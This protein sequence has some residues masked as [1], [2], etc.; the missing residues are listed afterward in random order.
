[1][2]SLR[3]QNQFLFGYK[4]AGS[5]DHISPSLKLDVVMWLYV[6]AN[7]MSVEVI[8]AYHLGLF[9]VCFKVRL[10][11]NVIF[12]CWPCLIWEFSEREKGI[13]WLQES[14]NQEMNETWKELSQ[15]QN[16]HVSKKDSYSLKKTQ[17]WDLPSFAMITALKKKSCPN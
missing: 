6:L 8:L 17:P 4:A 16:V 5:S 7:G 3:S 11:F 10:I 9:H 15:K 14:E 12:L 13:G 2:T 1:M